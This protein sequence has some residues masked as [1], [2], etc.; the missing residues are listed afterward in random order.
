[1][2]SSSSRLVK[3]VETAC[4]GS[5]A[6]KPNHERPEVAASSSG[7]ASSVVLLVSTCFYAAKPKVG[8][9]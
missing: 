3:C 6:P 7:S 4:P 8:E 5:A 9:L 1:M 2:T